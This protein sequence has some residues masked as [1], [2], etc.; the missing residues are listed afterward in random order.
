MLI[1]WISPEAIRLLGQGL[2]LTLALTVITSLSSM[3]VGIVFGVLRLAEN[4]FLRRLAGFYITVNRNIPALVQIIFWA[5]AF[6]NLFPVELRQQLFFNN[7]LVDWIGGST[8]LLVP[9]YTVAASFALTLNTS[10]YL[11]EIFRAGVGTIAQEQVDAARTLGATKRNVL[12][13][14][15]VPEGLRASFP[16]ISTRLIHNM[17]NT[18]LAALVS[19]PELFHNTLTSITRSFRA[20]EFL[21]LAAIIYL[22]LAFS[23][24]A[25]LRWCERLLYGSLEPGGDG[26]EVQSDLQGVPVR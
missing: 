26:A 13:Q 17:K 8:G 16:A 2:A 23:M 18:A 25:L 15:L 10:A 24:S 19:T 3:G 12:F 21:L 9:Y 4:A 7:A 20:V 1:S 22:A 5:Y 14:L 6:P 11:A